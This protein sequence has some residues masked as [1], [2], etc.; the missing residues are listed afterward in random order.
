M[1]LFFSGAS[2]DGFPVT[3]VTSPSSGISAANTGHPAVAGQQ[4]RGLKSG[5]CDGLGPDDSDAPELRPRMSGGVGGGSLAPASPTC[6]TTARPGQGRSV[7]GA[8]VP[9][10]CGRATAVSIGAVV[11]AWLWRPRRCPWRRPG[12]CPARS[13]RDS[14]GCF[15]MGSLPVVPGHRPHAQ[16]QSPFRS[17]P[18]FGHGGRV[19]RLQQGISA[20]EL[21]SLL[22]CS[23]NSFSV[24]SKR[25]EVLIGARGCEQQTGLFD[26]FLF[27]FRS[28]SYTHLL[29]QDWPECT[30]N[31]NKCHA[32]GSVHAM[33]WR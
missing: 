19:T 11:W 33:Y 9:F 1:G 29:H 32:L 5:L 8:R 27:V 10:Q 6:N 28:A 26:L 21:K 22:T 30:D 12:R 3:I 15:A 14:G 31:T 13:A 4:V 17:A 23:L 20:L 16:E 7:Y 18:Y 2:R 24:K 25:K